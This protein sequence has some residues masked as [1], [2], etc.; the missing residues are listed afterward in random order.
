VR[1]DRASAFLLLALATIVAGSAM[2]AELG[3]LFTSA[4]ERARLDRLRRGEPAAQAAATAGGSGRREVTGFVQRSD[5]LGTVW[6]DG[7]PLQVTSPRAAPLFDPKGVRAYS[8]RK[9]GDVKVE[10]RPPG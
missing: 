6:I 3:T 7:V 1:R 8:E 9:E 5:G 2:A 10:R 4:E